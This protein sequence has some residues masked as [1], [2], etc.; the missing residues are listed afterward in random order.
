MEDPTSSAKVFFTLNTQ[1]FWIDTSTLKITKLNTP[2]EY[3]IQ[4]ILPIG[5][6]KLVINGA[7]TLDEGYKEHSFLIYENEDFVEVDCH[8]FGIIGF[9][10]VACGDLL[11]LIS[12]Q[13]CQAYAISKGMYK[14]IKKMLSIHIN[15]G[16]CLFNGHVIVVG[17]IN[18][19][20]IEQYNP[21]VNKWQK[22]CD[23]DRDLFGVS[24]IQISDEEIIA[25]SYNEY[26]KINL[27]TGGIVYSDSLPIKPKS[28]RIGCPLRFNNYVFCIVGNTRLLRYNISTEKWIVLNRGQ[29]HCCRII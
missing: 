27:K 24:C 5:E 14:N 28:S 15:P 11:Y 8:D 4:D 23:L 21:V 29:N 16:C 10:M 13:K 12:E 1:I 18:N 25:I 6:N 17:G 22:V 2:P 7:K 9:K 20:T 3:F 26:Y 19:R